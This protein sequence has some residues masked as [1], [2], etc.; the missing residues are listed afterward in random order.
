[1]RLKKFINTYKDNKVGL[2]EKGLRNLH[3]KLDFSGDYI[4]WTGNLSLGYGQFRINSKMVLAHR[5][6]WCL[7][8]KC[9]FSDI[10]SQMVLHCIGY[11]RECV[12]PDHL[13][14]G[15]HK[16]NMLDMK[17]EG[18]GKKPKVDKRRYPEIIKRLKAGDSVEDIA[19]SEN[20]T[21]WTIYYIWRRTGVK[22]ERKLGNSNTLT[23]RQ[24]KNIIRK[25]ADGATYRELGKK[26]GVNHITIYN[27]VKGNTFKELD[28]LRKELLLK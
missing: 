24:A 16:Q 20:V 2:N 17:V 26:Y 21:P 10:K 1:M 4:Q 22:I 6:M 18:R 9:S 5:L 23:T 15:D 11:P 7:G 13:Y 28:S 3:K 12:D 14:L 19:H 27:I 8:N 25:K